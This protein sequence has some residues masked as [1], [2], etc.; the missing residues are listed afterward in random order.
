VN[1]KR[2]AIIALLLTSA[3]AVPAARGGEPRAFQ[4]DG[5]KS[6]V[7]IDVGKAGFF[8]AF[9]HEHRILAKAVS[10]RV[11]LN[12]EKIER[13]SLTLRVAASSLTV[14]DPGISESDRTEIQ[15]T[16][17]GDAVL[18]AARFPEIAFDSTGITAEGKEGNAWSLTLRG[19]LR[20]HGLEREVAFPARVQVTGEDL[21]ARGEVSLLQ[22]DYGIT[23]VKAAGGTVKVKDGVLIR[24]LIR[25][26]GAAP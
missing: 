16:M 18:G 19:K 15:S 23:P 11:V 5:P 20:L 6:S 14:A 25:A 22:T 9:G 4:I 8:K 1:G 7:E 3:G 10:G 17:L 12:E 24:F 2:C 13:S 26:R 21:E